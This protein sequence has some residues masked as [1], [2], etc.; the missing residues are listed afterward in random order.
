[1]LQIAGEEL[2]MDLSQLKFV[3]HD[4]NV[5]PD[6]GRTAASSSTRNA[7]NQVRAAAAHA[8]QALLGL[9]AAQ[10]GVPVSGL[11]VSK[12]VVSGGGKSVSYGQ[13]IGDKLFNVR[14]PASYNFVPGG[15]G[16]GNT[17]GLFPGVSPAKPVGEY[18]LV[19]TGPPRIDIPP[20]VVGAYAYIHNVRVPGMLHGR[21]VRPRGEG[22][23]GD[24]T[25]PKIISVDEGSIKHIPD[26]RV[27]RRGDYLGVVAAK[28]YDAIQAAA[29]LKVTWADPPVLPSSGNLWKQMR[30]HDSGAQAPARIQFASGNVDAALASAAKTVTAT[31]RYHYNHHAVIGP[32]CV[33]ADV[34]PEGA[35]IFTSSQDMYVARSR[36]VDLL[37]LPLNK[38]RLRY[39]EG[40][41]SY[42]NSQSRYE[43]TLAAAVM[44]QLAGAPVRLQLMRWD[45]HGWAN[46]APAVMVDLRG[47]VD[48]SGKLVA[49]D[50]TGFQIPAYTGNTNPTE[51]MVGMPVAAPGL[52]SADQTGQTQYRIPNRRVIAKSLPLIN[53]Y[54]K[55]ATMRAPGANQGVFAF[56]QMIDEL[57]HAANMDPLAFRLAN[58]APD[59]ANRVLGVLKALQTISAW[60]PKVAAS[61]LS[62]AKVVTGRGIASAPYSGSY[63]AVVADIEVNKQSGKIVAK[64]MYA[65]QDAGLGINPASLENQMIGSVVMSVSRVLFEAVAFDKRG[66]RSL[67]WVSYPI[68][69]FK[70]TP[71]VTAAVVQRTDQVSGGAGEIPVP[72]TMAAIANALFDATG[73]RVRESPLN[74]GRVRAALTAARK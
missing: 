31:Y 39:Y 38:I 36:L 13:L 52:G 12:G 16:T 20:K 65:A 9:A 8:K 24:G 19:G 60:T 71:T 32:C 30:A 7:G 2:D 26:V 57:A 48:A 66:V 58:L 54:F 42:G 64:H 17:A 73:V 74:P 47:G 1:M 4:T 23:Y 22:A 29:Q 70:E 46:F 11:S 55:T 5:T 69:R 15:T 49:T 14:M 37:G 63:A 10:L 40:S 41:S 67:D 18:K 53:N 56:E 27:V 45:E 44:S 35:T 25:A 62:D 21:V 34:R 28:E 6:T 3:V 43:V 68:L 59:P 72:S 33:L 61:N 50:Y 51:Q